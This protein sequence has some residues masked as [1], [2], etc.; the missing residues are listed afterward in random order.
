MAYKNNNGS[1]QFPEYNSSSDS[2]N[3]ATGSMRAVTNQQ[4]QPQTASAMNDPYNAFKENSKEWGISPRPSP[5]TPSPG[6]MPIKPAPVRQPFPIFTEPKQTTTQPGITPP[7]PTPPLQPQSAGLT[8]ATLARVLGGGMGTGTATSDDT[9]PAPDTTPPTQNGYAGISGVRAYSDPGIGKSPAAGVASGSYSTGTPSNLAGGIKTPTSSTTGANGLTATALSSILGGGASAGPTPAPPGQNPAPSDATQSSSLG[10]PTGSPGT[11]TYDPA[12][13]LWATPLSGSL[14]GGTFSGG[15]APPPGTSPTPNDPT[16][17]SGLG[18]PTGTP[19]Q[20]VYDPTTGLTA[21]PLSG[22]TGGLPHASAPPPVIPGTNPG[23]ITNPAGGHGRIAPKPTGDGSAIIQGSNVPKPDGTEDANIAAGWYMA[24]APGFYAQGISQ[25]QVASTINTYRAD[26]Q[27]LQDTYGITG[28]DYT[29]WMG[30]FHPEMTNTSSQPTTMRFADGHI[31][32]VMPAG[33][34]QN[35][36]DPAALSAA[37]KLKQTGYDP[38]AELAKRQPSTDANQKAIADAQA[39]MA[40]AVPGS[41]A[42]VA[43]QQALAAAQAK[44]KIPPAPPA[45]T[46][47]PPIPTPG[48]PPVTPPGTTPLTPAPP[49]GAEPPPAPP[50]TA[51]PPPVTAT[52]TSTPLPMPTST[53]TSFGDIAK[54]V[55]G[56]TDPLFKSKQADLART[57]RAQGAATGDINAGGF[58]TSL[59][60]GE[61]DLSAQQSSQEGQLVSS[62]Y[63]SAQ[64]RQTQENVAQLQADTAIA[65]T[66]TTAGM[67]QFIATMQDQTQRLGI[68]T[69]ADLQ[70]ALQNNTLLYQYSALDKNDLLERYKAQLQLQGQQFSANAQMNAAALSAATQGAA[71][72]AQAAA[73]QR[74]A[75]IQLTLGQG[76]QTI[77][78]ANL[79]AGVYNNDQNRQIEWA[80]LASQLGLSPAQLAQILGQYGPSPPVL[81]TP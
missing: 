58:N 74:A 5:V 17:G 7:T 69:N 40:S 19:G 52:P 48:T 31:E 15:A 16:Q 11:P 14:G 21:T 59:A 44:A 37:L 32:T 38:D 64:D 35:R 62:L 28:L 9:R 13:G 3:G 53:G 23:D 20:S 42:Y 77:D 68:Q 72:A 47:A 43:A 63:N 6:P 66:K 25:S 46:P 67:Q 54:T 55:S 78:W 79:Q 80:T 39:A 61:A 12:T 60:R 34:Y 49:T 50:G 71:I 73:S 1:D 24:S 76:Q 81:T 45:G 33:H 65:N 41:P 8:P 26:A 75:E 2:A 30:L 57:L 4:S 18:A 10:P 36:S 22:S 51:T 70:T 27:Y 56:M 29:D